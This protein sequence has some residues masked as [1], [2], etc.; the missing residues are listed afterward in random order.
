MSVEKRFGIE[1]NERLAAAT[2]RV[3]QGTSIYDFSQCGPFT[4]TDIKSFLCSSSVDHVEASAIMADLLADAPDAPRTG[5]NNLTDQDSTAQVI[6]YRVPFIMR[7]PE[8]K[9]ERDAE[10]R[11]LS[12]ITRK[13]LIGDRWTETQHNFLNPFRRALSIVALSDTE[14]PDGLP[15]I[16]ISTQD[17]VQTADISLKNCHIAEDSPLSSPQVQR[18]RDG[19]T[20]ANTKDDIVGET[21]T[22]G[23]MKP[24]HATLAQL[25]SA[26]EPAKVADSL[27][28]LVKGCMELQATGLKNNWVGAEDW[29]GLRAG[30]FEVMHSFIQTWV[31]KSCS[32]GD[33]TNQASKSMLPDEIFSKFVEVMKHRVVELLFSDGQQYKEHQKE[34][35][36]DPESDGELTQ[37]DI[38]EVEVY[39]KNKHN[40]KR[41]VDGLEFRHATFATGSWG[42]YLLAKS[43]VKV[44]KRELHRV[45]NGGDGDNDDDS[46]DMRQ[47][48][49]EVTCLLYS[50]GVGI[51][52]FRRSST[53]LDVSLRLPHLAVLLRL[54]SSML[55]GPGY[56]VNE[57][58]EAVPFYMSMSLC[59]S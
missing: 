16:Q 46:D 41:I 44:I 9:E 49:E 21:L 51:P 29:K 48:E 45:A 39:T 57:L 53:F 12:E 55:F 54:N 4:I 30:K 52:A 37:K 8:L 31:D 59:V 47:A 14:L 13:T 11:Y 38:D 19:H 32:T 24:I 33:F 43:M 26:V 42:N 1:R 3:L 7:W 10:P 22:D 15:N 36:W 23:Y 34:H 28:K 40:V 18:L 2:H 20:V 56:I 35:V 6:Q 17:D 50:L 25:L 27:E 58:E 5:R